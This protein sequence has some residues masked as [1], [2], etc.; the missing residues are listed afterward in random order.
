[1]S[2]W[3]SVGHLVRR[4][5]GSLSSRP[6]PDSDVAWVRAV[7]PAS[8][9]QCWATMALAD[10]RHSVLVA[11]RFVAGWPQ[12]S[13][14]E[15]AGALLHDVG[16]QVSRLS[17][18]ERVLATLLGPRTARWRRYHDHERVGAD[19]ARQLGADPVTVD[20]IRGIGPRA[21]ELRRADE[22]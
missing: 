22:L 12:A 3:G 4:F 16:K 1:M 18:A 13:D 14:A 9:F 8:L 17:T 5:F 20:L 10:R 11:R 2:R 21:A 7:L 15:V 6:L 19:L